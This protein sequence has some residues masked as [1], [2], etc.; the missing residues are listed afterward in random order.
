MY[1]LIE[2]WI[3][4]KSF[5]FE[6]IYKKKYN[7]FVKSYR[8]NIYFSSFSKKPCIFNIIYKN[9]SYSILG[10]SNFMYNNWPITNQIKFLKYCGKNKLNRE[11][12]E[13]LLYIY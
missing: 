9:K 2:L 12:M 8:N 11:E 5:L 3:I 7:K 1:I 13:E 4:I 10:L 6:N